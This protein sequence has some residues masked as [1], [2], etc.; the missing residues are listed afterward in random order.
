MMKTLGS[1]VTWMTL[2]I[3]F[4]EEDFRMH[5]TFRLLLFN[6]LHCCGVMSWIRFTCWGFDGSAGQ[7]SQRQTSFIICKNPSWI[8]VVT[9]VFEPNIENNSDRL[10]TWS[11]CTLP[12]TQA[13]QDRA[14]PH[15][16]PGWIRGYNIKGPILNMNISWKLNYNTN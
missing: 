3:Q 16:E 6:F 15:H 4:I 8:F 1:V 14:L 9:H 11:G 5:F 12:C 7:Y 10:D 13:S 2:C